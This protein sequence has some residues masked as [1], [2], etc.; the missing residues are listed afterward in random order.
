V[1]GDQ[2]VRPL[3]E[4]GADDLAYRPVRPDELG[5]CAEI[6]RTALNDY[7]G[8]LNL[9]GIPPELGPITR[10][11]GHIQATD[12][13]RFVVG[14]RQDQDAPD[15]SRIVAFTAA[16]RRESVW[17]L[18][19]LFVLP[20][21][22]AGGVGR[23]L[24]GRVLPGTDEDVALATGTDSAQPISNALYSTYG[25]VP[26]M[27]LLYLSGSPE[28]PE[29]FPALPSGISATRFEDVVG[30][31][32]G[33]G[34]GHQALAAIVETLDREL[35]G[36]A[37][38]ADHRF[39]RGEERHGWLYRGP[40]GSP[41]GYGYAGESGKVGPV[42]VRD[43]EL[44]APILGHLL[45]AVRARGSYAMW[46]PGHADRAVVPALAA[47][48]RLDQFP[49]LLCWSRPFADFRRYLPISPGL[50]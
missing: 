44:L 32:G 6:W 28:R 38:P 12:P 7:M 35:A 27:P 40:D 25:I 47:G 24:L 31:A 5:T 26:R 34:A 13:E 8:R 9:P 15:G 4:V 42:A 45:G 50:L 2:P 49:I 20:E 41:V 46:V 1:I 22:Q 21:A 14:L 3:R 19:M 39:L 48:F 17:F 23:A 37:H 16:V 18:S 33:G 30:G 43:E 11:Y 36:A 10:L 29:A